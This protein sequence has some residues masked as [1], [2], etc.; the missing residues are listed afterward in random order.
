MEREAEEQLADRER[1]DA[2]TRREQALTTRERE[3]E[4]EARW[5]MSLNQISTNT[6]Y[7]WSHDYHIIGSEG[8]VTARL[9]LMHSIDGHMTIT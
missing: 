8:H 1:M 4:E 5:V 9:V 7:R 6:Q 3:L 2:L